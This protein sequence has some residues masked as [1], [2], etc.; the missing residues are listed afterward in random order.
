MCVCLMGAEV[1]GLFEVVTESHSYG[2]HLRLFLR[3]ELAHALFIYK[4]EC[5]RAPPPPPP[6]HTPLPSEKTLI[7]YAV[8]T[9]RLDGRVGAPLRRDSR[10]NRLK[11]HCS[12]RL[13]AL[14]SESVKRLCV[15]VYVCVCGKEVVT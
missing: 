14:T 8:S 1:G 3:Q 7:F 13:R 12:P 15:F 4:G 2:P 10:D 9:P 6:P 11:N 5:E